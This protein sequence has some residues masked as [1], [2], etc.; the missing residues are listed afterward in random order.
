MKF[1][2]L[3]KEQVK[4]L[5]DVWLGMVSADEHEVFAAEY[6]QLFDGIEATEGYGE[7]DQRYNMAIFF[8]VMDDEGKCWALVELV[9]SRRGRSVW[10]KMMDVYLSP[11]LEMAGDTEVSTDKR[12][13]VFKVALLSIFSLTG[14]V[15]GADTVKVYGRT[16]AIFSFLRGMHDTIAL[17]TSLGTLQGIQVSIEGRWLVFRAS[18]S[19]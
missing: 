18:G 4:E 5:K 9:Q 17:M 10:I 11:E 12:L 6:Q 16:D 13:N 14:S 3:G 1:C 8:G 7:L 15:S 2:A 19:A